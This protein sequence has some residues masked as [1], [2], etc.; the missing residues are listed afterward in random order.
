MKVL[1]YEGRNTMITGQNGWDDGSPRVDTQQSK[2]FR[3]N[4]LLTHLVNSRHFLLENSLLLLSFHEASDDGEND[5]QIFHR[6]Y[7]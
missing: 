4:H 7:S 2:A 3:R 1:D 6:L 5:T